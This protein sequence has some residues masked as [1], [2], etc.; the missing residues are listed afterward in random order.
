MNFN[1]VVL[2]NPPPHGA[3][4]YNELN[5][6][7]PVCDTCNE[8]IL[9]G[10]FN[11]NWMV[12]S[13]K[14]K[15]KPLMEKFKYKQLIDKPTRITRKSETLIDL[16][17]TNRPE[18]AV[19]TYNLIT[20]LS[21]HNMILIVRKLTKKRLIHHSKIENQKTT[22]IPKSKMAD[23]EYELSQVNWETITKESTIN[24][25][26]NNFTST[27]GSLISKHTKT[28]KSRPKKSSLPWFN[29]DIYQLIKKRDL[30]LKRSLVMKNNTDHLTFTSL[31]NKVVSALWKAKSN[32]FH[33]LI[34][35]AN[36]SSSKLWQ[37]I[38][39]LTDTSKHKHPKITN[40]KVDNNLIDSNESIANAFNHFFVESVH[41]LASHFKSTDL[42]TSPE[43]CD[44]ASLD[45]FRIKE[46]SSDT[47]KKVITNM[48]NSTSKDIDN[49]NAGLIKKYQKYL[50]QPITHL[51]NLSIRTNT[52]PESWKTAII[53]P[54][55]KSGDKDMASN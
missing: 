25:N 26:V 27:L 23:F 49:L 45:G 42:K 8:C 16:I 13:E 1:I 31:R 38:H 40:L 7:L 24:H 35:E 43:D 52:F 10:D 50:L 30:A 54:I 6:L 21:D 20:G 36:G 18:R 11:I 51:V 53:T 44:N 37:Q 48:N 34:E 22:G 4:F 19:K 3:D 14:S 32:Y 28:W 39:R 46:V 9:L 41:E 12:K 33:K 5:S 15:L 17:F 55:Y 2:Y 47:V 29:N